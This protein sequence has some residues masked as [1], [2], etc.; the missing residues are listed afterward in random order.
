[1]L[2]WDDRAGKEVAVSDRPPLKNIGIDRVHDFG[3]LRSI[4]IV[5]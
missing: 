2:E 5:I 1:M 4:I 3:S